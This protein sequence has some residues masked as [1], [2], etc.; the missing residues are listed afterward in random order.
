M[1][2]LRLTNL[3]VQEEK[4]WELKNTNRDK[5]EFVL[6]L[7]MESLRVCGVTLTPIV[8]SISK[9]LLDKLGIPQSKRF[10]KDAQCL[11]WKSGYSQLG[12][13][14]KDKTVLYKKLR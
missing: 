9:M 12:L 7:T 2:V 8:P 4:P 10:W 3:F 11:S 1:D 13:L 5:L 6:H 14:S